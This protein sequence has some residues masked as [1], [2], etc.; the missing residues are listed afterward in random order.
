MFVFALQPSGLS[1][2]PFTSMSMKPEA[3]QILVPFGHPLYLM[4]ALRMPCVINAHPTMDSI[5]KAVLER[6]LGRAVRGA[7]TR[8][9]LC[10]VAGYLLPTGGP[11]CRTRDKNDCRSPA[12]AGSDSLVY[13]MYKTRP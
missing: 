11:A 8:R 3:G 10:R 6:L 7:F 12:S 1:R 9:S 4:D 2:S 5:Q 13:F